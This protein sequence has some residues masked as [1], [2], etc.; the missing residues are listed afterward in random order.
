MTKHINQSFSINNLDCFFPKIAGYYK[1]LFIKDSEIWKAIGQL[2]EYIHQNIRPNLDNTIVWGVP[3]PKHMVLLSTEWIYDGFEIVC[4]DT[5]KGKLE[6]RIDGRPVRQA[7]LVCAGSVFTDNR[8]QIGKGVFIESGTMIKGPS[9]IGDY[10]EVRQGAYIRGNCLI[11]SNCVIGH[12]TEVK[13]SIFLDGSKAGHFAYIGD[14][15]LGRNVNLGAGTKLAN[16]RFSSG[17]VSIKIE[18]ISIN[19][20][21]RKLGAIIGD[22][23]QTGCNSVT[24]PGALIGL[25]SIIAPNATVKPGFYPPRS[26]IR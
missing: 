9:I 3:L 19:T 22:N 21:M 23:S 18:D 16:L 11:G 8:I 26:I 1:G 2:N 6:V 4:D 14:S 12:T 5:T 20:G 17:N 15:I 13:H 24:N 10:T 25:Y 7:S